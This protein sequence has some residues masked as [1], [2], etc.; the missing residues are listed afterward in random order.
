MKEEV[1][2]GLCGP[3]DEEDKTPLYAQIYEYI[4]EEIKA[5][6]IPAYTR[7]PSTR[8]LSA[9]LGVSRSTVQLAYDQLCSEGYLDAEPC[10]GYYAARVDRPD[11]Q[12]ESDQTGHQYVTKAG[13]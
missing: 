10:R 9:S 7:L 12:A 6:V 2:R 3:L 8:G 11:W 1:L 4:R 5:G 13:F